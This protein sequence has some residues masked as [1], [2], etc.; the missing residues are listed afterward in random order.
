MFSH[1]FLTLYVPRT[2]FVCWH[3]YVANFAGCLDVSKN[4]KYVLWNYHW[5]NTLFSALVDWLINFKIWKRKFYLSSTTWIIESIQHSERC[6][7]MNI[8]HICK[9]FSKEQ[10][11]FS[12]WTFKIDLIKR[13]SFWHHNDYSISSC[14][15]LTITFY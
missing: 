15:L 12:V 6:W 8:F 1:Q 14:G 13:S 5:K 7:N 3:L 10:T 4:F 11:S 2:L 9:C